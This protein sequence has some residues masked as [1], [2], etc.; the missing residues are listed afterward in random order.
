MGSA[1]GGSRSDAITPHTHTA[2]APAL[3]SD[4]S[5]VFWISTGAGAE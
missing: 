3:A 2:L 1:V 4:N 5:L